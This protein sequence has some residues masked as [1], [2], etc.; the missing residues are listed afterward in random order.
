MSDEIPALIPSFVLHLR[1]KNLSE[2][3]V[4]SYTEAATQLARFLKDSGRRTGIDHIERGDI[5][6]FIA[7]IL[8]RHKPSTAANR[9]RS[10]QQ[11]FKWATDDPAAGTP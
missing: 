5:E 8:E 11:F 1:A 6:A 2:R 7:D 10:L 9:F 4:Q 3:T